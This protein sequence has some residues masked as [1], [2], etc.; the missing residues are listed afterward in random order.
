MMA[1]YF[2]TSEL[3]GIGMMRV[4]RQL[5]DAEF[6]KTIVVESKLPI[7]RGVDAAFLEISTYANMTLWELKRIVAKFTGAS[8]LCLSLKRADTKK[9]ELKD[10]RNCK[11][12]SDLKFTDEEVLS[13]TRAA[14]PEVAKTDLLD[15]DGATVPELKAIV[16]S[17]FETF[18]VQLTREEVVEISR[19]GPAGLTPEQI[20]LLPD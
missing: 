14:P 7:K 19:K 12:L 10:F 6:L 17:W 15:K 3:L 16:A 18:S 20:A 1:T 9:I 5:E 2:E 4:H 8:P 13:V 11:L